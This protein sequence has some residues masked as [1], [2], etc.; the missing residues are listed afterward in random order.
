MNNGFYEAK[1]LKNLKKVES[2]N[3][4]KLYDDHQLRNVKISDRIMKYSLEEAGKK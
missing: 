1:T 4:S 3:Q 2:G